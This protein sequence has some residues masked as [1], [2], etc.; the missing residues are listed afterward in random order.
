VIA[1]DLTGLWSCMRYE[2]PQMLKAGAGSIVNCASIAGLVG[3]PGLPAYVAAKHGVVGLT[4][5][6]ALE[7]ARQA[8]RVN[9]VCPGL[10]DTP[11]SRKGLT[12]EIAAK[13][14]EESP[15][16]RFGQPA[17]IASAVLW[18]CDETSG[19]LTG[20]AIAVDGAWTAR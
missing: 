3:A 9:A 15:I 2:I 20:Q 14:A 4:K 1:T 12:P 7:Y 11:M 17:E 18:L 6:A 13:L 16:G 10:I 5:A 19:F 8:I